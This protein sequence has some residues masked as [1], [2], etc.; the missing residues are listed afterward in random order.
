MNTMK[1][2]PFRRW[3]AASRVR[4]IGALCLAFALL[5]GCTSPSEPKPPAP[6]L[7]DDPAVQALQSAVDH[8]RHQNEVLVQVERAERR[9]QAPAE[10]PADVEALN[11][12]LEIR[13]W[14]GTALEAVRTVGN[15]IAYSVEVSGSRPPVAPL[16]SLDAAGKSAWD[17]IYDIADQ[18]ER[19]LDLRIDIE[20][21]VIVIAYRDRED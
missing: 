9:T 13:N 12:S 4:L 21:E 8:I 6:T 3:T 16:V 19:A 11:R 14:S 2:L 17:V 15:Q 18:A 5:V 20:R 7:A 10:R 1:T